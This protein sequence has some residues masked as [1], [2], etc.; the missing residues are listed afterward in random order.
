ML[1]DRDKAQLEIVEEIKD[2]LK[3]NRDDFIGS[4]YPV[5]DKIE[6]RIKGGKDHGK[7]RRARAKRITISPQQIR[8]NL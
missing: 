5:L 7:I 3:T 4:V 8:K 1:T 6:G 2:W